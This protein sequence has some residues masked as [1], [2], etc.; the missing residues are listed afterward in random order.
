MKDLS[1]RMQH[2][3]VS[4]K[5]RNC[6]AHLTIY[7]APPE[8]NGCNYTPIIYAYHMVVPSMALQNW[9]ASGLI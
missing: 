9:C 1:T 6:I 5:W 8:P 3:S 7:S 2:R 4:G